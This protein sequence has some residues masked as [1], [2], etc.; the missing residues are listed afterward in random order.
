MAISM[1]S[2]LAII[3]AASPGFIAFVGLL[4]E[5]LRNQNKQ[6]NKIEEVHLL[7]NTNMAAAVAEIAAL[8]VSIATTRAS[9][10]AATTLAAAKAGT[11]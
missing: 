11:P 9:A 3:A 8:R 2:A 6:I 10:E 1:N 5:V 4:I 7:V